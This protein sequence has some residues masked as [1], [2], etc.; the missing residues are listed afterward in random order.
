MANNITSSN[1]VPPSTDST[2]TPGIDDAKSDTNHNTAT[3]GLQQGFKSVGNTMLKPFALIKSG[4]CSLKDGMGRLIQH[5]FFRPQ[6]QTTPNKPDVTAMVI[7]MITDP[8]ERLVS[9]KNV[10]KSLT[11]DGN[12]LEKNG[13]ALIKL[14]MDNPTHPGFAKGNIEIPAE[15]I[16]FKTAIRLPDGTEIKTLKIDARDCNNGEFRG[17]R[18]ID[19]FLDAKLDYANL[20]ELCD[21]LTNDPL[22]NFMQMRLADT[23]VLA[24]ADPTTRATVEKEA[25]DSLRSFVFLNETTGKYESK[26][27]VKNSARPTELNVKDQP[28]SDKRPDM[29]SVFEKTDADQ[30]G[31]NEAAITDRSTRTVATATNQQAPFTTGAK[32]S[33]RDLR[34]HFEKT[35]PIKVASNVA[36]IDNANA[37]PNKTAK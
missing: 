29:R 8:A 25:P 36:P 12:V 16:V 18:A 37:S 7:K 33:V 30:A 5:L 23:I 3:N 6:T 27:S 31:S 4:I 28:V 34:K 32:N 22:R 35:G 13:K 17:Q 20:Q 21:K 10:L 14:L 24:M 26:F 19:A 1:R 2:V 9:A 11:N 15:T